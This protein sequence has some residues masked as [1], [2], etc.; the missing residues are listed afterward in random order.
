VAAPFGGLSVVLGA[1]PWR[2]GCNGVIIAGP[3]TP[4]L[5]LGG[6]PARRRL[7]SREIVGSGGYGRL[8]MARETAAQP[9][10]VCGRPTGSVLGVC[11]KGTPECLREYNRRRRARGPAEPA[12]ARGLKSAP[13]EVCG[14]PTEGTLGVCKRPGACRREYRRRYY[15]ATVKAKPKARQSK[16]PPCEVCDA[17]TRSQIGVCQ[18]PGPCR[19]E[20]NRR[21]Y[22]ANT[23][24]ERARWRT[25]VVA[26]PE[27]QR[28]RRHQYYLANKERITAHNERWRLENPEAARAIRHRANAKYRQRADRPCSYAAAGCTEPAEVGRATC[29]A[30]GR[31]AAGLLQAR[32]RNGLKQR[33][34]DKQQ[35]LC[36]WCH[37]PLPN[38]LDGTEIDHIIPKASGIVIEDEWNLALLHKG[39]NGGAKRD[40]ITKLAVKLAKRH[41]IVLNPGMGRPWRTRTPARPAQPPSCSRRPRESGEG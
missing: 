35:G 33:L 32:R 15:A 7:R 2:P 23:E 24:A 27:K 17:P 38:D 19:R 1:P 20:Y 18:R 34:A 39:C 13:C 36:R 37:K 41:G 6:S 14:N 8:V 10:E 16:R 5:Y 9:C 31:V 30:H 28:V 21:F 4:A 12:G 29:R 25:R 3:G 22:A 11:A 26:D 40:K